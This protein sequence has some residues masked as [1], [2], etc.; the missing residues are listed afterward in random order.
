VKPLNNYYAN[1][2]LDLL[3]RIPLSAQNV[4]EIG[5]GQG[6][7]GGAFKGRQPLVKYFGVELMPEEAKIAATHL[8]A[9]VC[10]NIELDH[11]IPKQFLTS[12]NADELFDALVLGDVLEHLQDPWK[13]LREAHQWMAPN[14]TCIVCIP[15]VG[16]WSVVQQLLKG[17]FDYAEAGLLDKTH[18]RFFTLETAIEMLRQAGWTVVEA[19]P[20]TFQPE[21]TQEALNAILPIAKSLNLNEA[22]L[23]RDLTAFQW[24]IRAVKG[25]A[26]FAMCV[27]ALGLKKFAGVTEAR[28][29]YPLTALNSLVGNRCVWSYGGISFPPD[30]KPGVLILHRQFMNDASFN[31]KMEKLIQEGW[32][33]VADMDDDPRHWQQFVESDFYAYR[34]VHAVTV[35]SQH[36]A[37]MLGSWNSHVKVF[38]NAIMSLPFKPMQESKNQKLPMRVFFGALNRKPDWQPIMSAIYE[39]ADELQGKIEFVVVHDKEFF[40]ALPPNCL[41]TFHPTLDHV[42]Y[43]EVLSACDVALL[44]LNDTPFNQCKSDIKLIECAAAGVAVICSKVVY[45]EDSRH[46]LFARFATNPQDWGN[47]LLHLAKNPKDLMQCQNLGLQYVKTNRMHA[48]QVLERSLYYRTLIENRQQLELDRQARLKQ[49]KLV[50]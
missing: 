9:V 46:E 5:C 4:L 41:K 32:T 43:M 6:K 36:L 33:L 47:A 7:L 14:S 40:D 19:I 30:F 21:K 50:A 42:N 34:A 25:A 24:V 17:R 27:G 29:D 1:I 35:S 37:N 38:P 48:Q 8:D 44:P 22:K 45:A 28:V 26:P 10:A 39:A 3:N 31:A 16:H 2:N 18:L 20:R 23:K 11:Q 12:K 49:L 15:N 13:L